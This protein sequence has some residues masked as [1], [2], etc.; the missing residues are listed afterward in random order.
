MET[1]MIRIIKHVEVY[2]PEYLGKKDILTAGEQ[3][4]AIEDQIDPPA[5]F[6]SLEV[7]EGE[8]LIAAPGFIDSHVHVT[9]GGGEGSY[10]SRTPE[11]KLSDATRAGVTT[12]IGVLGTDGMTRSMEN[13]IAKARGLREE[14]ISCWILTGSYQVPI[15]TLT[16]SIES[17]I[18]MIS[19]IIGVGEVAISD[20]RS[21]QPTVEDIAKMVAAARVGGMLSG[22]AGVVNFHLGDGKRGLSLIKE[23]IR[24]S[25]LPYHHFVPTHINRNAKLFEEGVVYARD[26]GFIDF[27]TSTTPQFLEEGEVKCSR[28]LK[29]CLDREVPPERITFTSDGQGSLPE[30]NENGELTGL[31][32]GT[33]ESLFTAVREAVQEEDVPLETA[34]RVVTANPAALYKL[35]RKGAIQ[36]GLDADLVLLN[37][38]DLSIKTVMAMGKVMVRDGEAVVKGLFE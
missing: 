7:V 18:I 24:N 22:K 5:S 4:A 31:R 20:H 3:I 35:P 33:S 17:D 23:V 14:G 32:V 13:L 26:G 37:A 10:K 6:P 2:A 16:K 12:V 29:I 19:E 11:M 25:E 30:F 34:L 15:R 21:S 28:A 8:G 9:G 27:T 38:E 36:T 1:P